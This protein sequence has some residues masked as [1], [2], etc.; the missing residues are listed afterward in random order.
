MAASTFWSGICRPEFRILWGEKMRKTLCLLA[1]GA[2]A[3]GLLAA[4]AGSQA[5][6]AR[7]FDRLKALVGTWESASPQ[8]G[9]LTNTI[10]LV[11]NGSALEEIFQMR[12]WLHP[13]TGETPTGRGR[14][15]V[16]RLLNG[17]DVAEVPHLAEAAKLLVVI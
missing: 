17:G 16:R 5:K 12:Y 9:I 6:P 15:P 7:G 2:V 11:S 1:L 10:R 3:I 14:L 4:R 8:G 13:S